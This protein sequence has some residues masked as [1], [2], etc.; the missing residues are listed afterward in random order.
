M[1]APSAT[2]EVVT[3][4]DLF[5]GQKQSLAIKITTIG[6]ESIILS[7]P[8]GDTEKALMSIEEFKDNCRI[9]FSPSKPKGFADPDTST[10]GFVIIAIPA[11]KRNEKL[12]LTISFESFL[13]EPHEGAVAI[14]LRGNALNSEPLCVAHVGKSGTPPQIKV[15]KATSYNVFRGKTADLSWSIDRECDYELVE[16]DP[17]EGK[18]PDAPLKK[19]NGKEGNV[20][21]LPAGNYT[22]KVPDG[23][24]WITRRLCINGYDRTGFHSYSLNLS[25][26][27]SPTEIL[28]LYAYPEGNRGV[29]RPALRNREG[30]L[31]ALVR[32]GAASR[33]A[34]LWSTDRGFDERPETWQQVTNGQGQ[35]EV[36]VELARR[37]GVIF[38]DRLWLLGGDCCRP[39]KPGRNVQYYDFQEGE[40]HEVGDE[41]SR[42]WP[43][44]MA[45]RMGHAVVTFRDR[46]WVMGGWSQN[47]GLCNDIWEFDGNSWTKLPLACEACLFGA[48]ATAEAVWQVGGF[49]SPGG[50]ASKTAI[51]RYDKNNNATPI[52]FSI[53]KGMQYC[54]S[55]LFALDEQTD[56]PC[57]IGAFYDPG[58]SSYM[59][60][61]FF[62]DKERNYYVAPKE[63]D[64]L[65]AQG[66]ILDR[67]YYHIQATVFQG[68]AFFRMLRPDDKPASKDKTVSYLVWVD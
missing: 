38:R 10:V 30:R 39:D 23:D 21:G 37:P 60:R 16:N 58:T 35:I 34:Q 47:G 53:A 5:A 46:I 40:W 25:K 44:G 50:A 4:D 28:G 26:D 3:P 55:A 52:D 13:V 64:T 27:G 12:P 15:F 54:A 14:E 43:K 62:I 7:V 33:V 68:A 9:K 31:Y 57:G 36:T 2:I 29:D 8:V 61:A 1:T 17:Y 49:A 11:R 18:K 22:L 63:I 19:G 56:R 32:S 24:K 6:Y 45:R 41:D 67:D 20:K 65:S 42:A 51:K 59:D 48:T 66:V